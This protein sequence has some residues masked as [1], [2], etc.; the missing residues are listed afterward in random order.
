MALRPDKESKMSKNGRRVTGRELLTGSR[1]SVI[2]GAHDGLSARLVQEAGFDGIWA[3]S[4][5]ISLAS[6]CLPDTDLITMTEN[7][8]SV[9][10]MTS[11]ADV[12]VIAD[13]SAGYGNATNVQRLVA[14]FEQAGVAGISIEDNPVPKRCSLYGGWER[15]MVPIPEMAG[16][17]RAAR[18]ARRDDGFAVIARTEA[19]IGDFG[20]DVALERAR[21]YA[22]AGADALLVHAK[23]FSDWLEFSELWDGDTPLVSVPT[24]FPEVSFEELEERGIKL[25]IY[26][27]QAIRASIKAMQDVLGTILAEQRG[28]AAEPSIVPLSE[29]YRIVDVDAV[30]A[31]EEAY[32]LAGA[33]TVEAS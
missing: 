8:E 10:Q 24:L 3:S 18:D 1:M 21:A 11:A 16:K 17:I 7:L 2:G 5:G 29:V 31:A 25:A 9:R 32:V 22:A 13:V 23:R 14:E 28:K 4:F 33:E 6:R 30:R 20:A 15:A 19:L 27:N 26:P 12:P